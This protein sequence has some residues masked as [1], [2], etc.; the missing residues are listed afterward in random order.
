MRILLSC[1]QS[2]KRHPLPAYDFWRP[3]FVQGCEEA[4]IECAEVPGVDWAEGLIHPPGEDLEEWRA[5]TWE[6]VLAF[7]RKEHGR[8]PILFFLS[9]LYPKQVD[10]TAIKELHRMGIPT[11]NFFCDNVREFDRVPPEYSPFALHW[12]P[13]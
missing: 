12:V 10:P 2:L 13:E 4:G 8:H 11:V 3:Y 7:V 9:Y 5:R 6:T 1:L